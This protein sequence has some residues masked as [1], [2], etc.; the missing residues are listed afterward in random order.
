VNRTVA[1]FNVSGDAYRSHFCPWRS[2][3]LSLIVF[4]F[5]ISLEEASAKEPGLPNVDVSVAGGYFEAPFPLK[6]IPSVD[7]AVYSLH[8]RWKRNQRLR[9]G[10]STAMRW[11]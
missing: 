5:A 6:L 11:R 9:M 2:Q 1:G 3:F 7:G 4:L 8:A 10:M